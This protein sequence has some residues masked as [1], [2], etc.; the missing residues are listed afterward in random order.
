MPH[1]R[2]ARVLE[3][4]SSFLYTDVKPE[5]DD[6]FVEGQVGS[7]SSTLS[8]LA[9]QLEAEHAMTMRQRETLLDGLETVATDCD[10]ETVVEAAESARERVAEAGTGDGA[11]DGGVDEVQSALVDAANDV[12]ATIDREL[13][14]DAARAARRPLYE[15]LRVRVEGQLEMLGRGEE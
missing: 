8:F 2:P 7:M 9:Q 4:F 12:L 10:D 11:G 14:G 3:R 6:E 15:F 13:D 5:I 1:L